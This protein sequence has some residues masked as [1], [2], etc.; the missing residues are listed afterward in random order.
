[1]K[2]DSDGDVEV[3]FDGIDAVQWVF[4]ANVHYLSETTTQPR[5]SADD[6]VPDFAAKSAVGRSELTEG[7]GVV[8]VREFATN[9]A[10]PV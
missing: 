2:V 5:G 4:H 9:S 6:Q 7:A 10:P 8:V 3:D 1:M